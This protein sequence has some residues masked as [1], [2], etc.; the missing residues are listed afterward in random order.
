MRS[1]LQ[2]RTPQNGNGDEH[3]VRGLDVAAASA[4]NGSPKVRFRE[5]QIEMAHG[6]G[7]KA[8]RR[9]VEGLFAPLLFP[10]STEPLGDAA[11]LDFNGTRIAITTDSF[12]V[13]PLTFPGGSIGELAVNGTV[14]DLA[15]SG[16][17]AEAMVVTYVLEAGLTTPVLEA[18]VRAMGNAARKA[19][20]RIAGGDTKV[21]EHGKAD[22][23]YITTTGIG[24][25]LHGVTL[26]PRSVRPGDK[27]LLSGPIGDHGITILLARGDLDLEADLCS[28]TR[29]VLPLVE[30][31]VKAAGPGVRWMRDPTRGGVA[32]SLNELARD[33]GLGVVLIEEQLPVRDAVRGACELLGLDPL[34][35][36]NE[37]QFLAVV[38]PEYADA[39]L[40][41]LN[42]SSGGEDAQ[43]I[44]EVREQPAG[45]VL[46]T[47][48]YGGSRIVDMLVG[49]PL[50]RIC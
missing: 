10:S 18:E 30:A 47:T 15:V 34:H 46:V 39:A 21:V 2:L 33:C 3:I 41:A 23:M 32:T 42:L 11:H 26:D 48:L 24:R 4:A 6:A 40:N 28:D 22:S 36:A 17:R 27:I 44:G 8:S 9:L 7:G 43:V 5:P 16:A 1:V 50:P 31:L 29:S 19:G 49:D 14:N 38:G 37:G 25:P 45:A 20:V 35:I 12:V 13:K